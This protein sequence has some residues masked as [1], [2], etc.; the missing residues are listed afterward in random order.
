M[1]FGTSILKAFWEGLGMVLGLY[2]ASEE[3]EDEQDGEDEEN[4]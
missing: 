3:E 2:W 4:E 1:L